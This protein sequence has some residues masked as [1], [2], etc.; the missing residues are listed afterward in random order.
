MNFEPSGSYPPHL[1][2]RPGREGPLPDPLGRADARASAARSSAP[3]RSRAMRNVI[4]SHGGSYAL[5]R[6]LAVSSGALDPIRAAR[7]HQ[8][9]SGRRPSARSRNGRSPEKIV[10]L[11]PWGHLVAED[12]S[13]GDRRRPRHPPDHRHHQGAPRP[14]RDARRARGRPAQGRRQR[15]ARQRQP[16]GDQGRDRSGLVSAR[17][18]ASASAPPRP[19]CAARC[20]S[21]PAACS[22]SW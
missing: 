4:G 2:S 15:R 9:P 8:H 12:F 19:R 10:S 22:R 11:D 6:A 5:Y 21:R 1:A 3:C 16:V 18:R 14:D 20:S 17:H 13:A 7:P